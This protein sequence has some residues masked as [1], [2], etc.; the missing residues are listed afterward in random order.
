VSAG[1]NSVGR[2]IGRWFGWVVKGILYKLT[3]LSSGDL[4]IQNKNDKQERE[5]RTRAKKNRTESV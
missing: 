5:N 4:R 3:E 2:I 1:P